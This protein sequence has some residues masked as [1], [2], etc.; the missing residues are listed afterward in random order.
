MNKCFVFELF[1]K[2]AASERTWDF[3]AE[4]LVKNYEISWWNFY[5]NSTKKRSSLNF[6][7]Q[8]S[9]FAVMKNV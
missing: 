1:K 2:N 7:A 6:K 3:F 4:N 8:S 5:E 9:P